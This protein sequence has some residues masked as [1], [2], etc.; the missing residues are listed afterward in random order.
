MILGKHRHHDLG[1][2]DACRPVLDCRTSV[3][4]WVGRARGPLMSTPAIEVRGLRKTYR[5][6]RRPTQ[7]ALD[8]LDMVVEAG[9]VQGLLGP[10]GSG[11]TTTIRVLLGLARADGGEARVLG[12]PVPT[13]L[14]QVVGHVGA[15]VENPLFLPGLTGRTSLNLLARS[16]GVP[17]SRVEDVLA[18]VRLLE[19]A[20]DR[21][22]TYSL[23]MRQRL[24]I[25]AAL[26][27]DPQL[28]I[29]DEP[30]NGLDPAGM[31]EVR[32]LV[33]E[34][35]TGG[36]TVVIS[37]HLL[38]EVQQVCDRV[39]IM[40]RGRAL[41]SGPVDEVLRAHGRRGFVVGVADHETAAAVLRQA[42][43]D[44]QPMPDG[45]LEVGTTGPPVDDPATLTRLLGEHGVWL[46]HLAPAGGD[47]ESAFLEIT[48]G[49]GLGEADDRGGES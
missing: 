32:D 15:L 30:S 48:S 36:R 19:R 41:L 38:S 7:R 5:S 3:P 12:H 16:V 20:D 10:N 6:L 37:S 11:K 27:K 2:S 33:R 18:S 47:L 49:G 29:L 14:R 13:Q 31:K 1:E 17:R 24:G 42:G 4:T 8:G 34:L 26:L 44:V 40:S 25:A 46:H 39:T 35:G 23:G 43:L 9:G 28:L 45:R 22:K 21:V